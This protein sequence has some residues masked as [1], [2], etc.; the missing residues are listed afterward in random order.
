[1]N[2]AGGWDT[3][4]HL[5]ISFRRYNPNGVEA[6]LGQAYRNKVQVHRYSADTFYNSCGGVLALAN[7]DAN[8]QPVWPKPGSNN[9]ADTSSPLL[10]VRVARIDT[11]GGAAYINVCRA[12]SKGRESG[13]QCR[14]G[15]DNDCDG[16]VDNC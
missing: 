5:F 3:Y 16:K 8:D 11:V 7:L 9:P 4:E 14:D 1:M 10:A 15:L 2:G 13:A 6:G 12:Q